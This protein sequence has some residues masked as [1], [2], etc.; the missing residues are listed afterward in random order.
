MKF[1]DELTIQVKAGKGGD[2]CCSFRRE[3]FIPF[4]GPDGGN[5]GNG[6]DIYLRATLR[7]NT[8]VDLNYRKEY[9]ADKGQSGSGNLRSGKFG[10]NLII[11][12]PIG[13]IVWENDTGEMI[14]DLIEED[15]LLLVAQGG[16]GGLGNHNF[17]SSINRAPRKIIKG[18]LGEERN[19]RL[20]LRLLADVGLLGFPNVGKSTFISKVSAAKPKIADYPFTTIKPHLGM[21]RCNGGSFVIADIPGIL[22]GASAGVGLGIRF[23]KHLSRNKLLLHM[24]DLSTCLPDVYLE[25]DFNDYDNLIVENLISQI[26]VIET[27]LKT[28]N[29]IQLNNI[30]R[31]I[32]I[33]KIDILTMNKLSNIIKKIANYNIA[34]RVDDNI[35]VIKELK[36]TKIYWISAVSGNG[37]Q[38]LCNDIMVYLGV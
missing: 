21:V 34:N 33:N 13:T 35:N 3:K 24:V 7:L 37:V 36:N 26:K 4:G 31:W 19:L 38:Q 29:D 18:S 14:G 16:Q 20:E 8:L 28:Y 25:E 23:L 6:G 5:G 27:E 11:D 17:K 2:G 9:K 12:V 10:E 15:Q 1:I 30:V 32:V 22:E